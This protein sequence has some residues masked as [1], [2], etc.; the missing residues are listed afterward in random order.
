MEN[1]YFIAIIPNEEIC[2]E[3]E[4]FKLDFAEHFESRHALRVIPHITLK[5]PFKLADSKHADLLNWFKK[6]FIS[7]KPFQIELKN[8][9]AFHN[10]NNPV[11][12]VQPI[13]NTC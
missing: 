12:Y 6:L 1:L 3:I 5:A 4:S 2:V 8:F 7:T 9:G 11:V 10:K 13:M